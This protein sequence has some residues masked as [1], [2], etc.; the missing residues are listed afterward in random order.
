MSNEFHQRAKSKLKIIHRVTVHWLKLCS[1]KVQLNR[2]LKK[3]LIN[4]NELQTMWKFWRNKSNDRSM[5]IEI[6]AVRISVKSIRIKWWTERISNDVW[7]CFLL[8]LRS[9]KD[10]RLIGEICYQF[11]RRIL[12]F[13]FPKTK[14]L[15]GYSMRSL[16]DLIKSEKN[17]HERSE[18]RRRYQQL[19]H[20]LKKDNFRFERHSEL[21]F[22]LINRFGIY[23]D[24]NWLKNHR[25]LIS[26]DENLKSFCFSF[27]NSKIHGDFS[28]IFDSFR[29]V[30]EFDGRPLFFC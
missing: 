6:T 13:I 1:R 21:T 3:I 27:L 19:E 28:I 23:S 8:F 15:Y 7:F 26:N 17:H 29:S 25:D 12:L 18:C 5:R 14:H 16:F 11:E 24:L 9:S 4:C 20:L 2:K 30:A 10:E 22:E